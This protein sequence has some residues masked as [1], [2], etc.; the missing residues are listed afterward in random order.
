MPK[1]KK[2]D[3]EAL[4]MSIVYAL[5]SHGKLTFS[6][7]AKKL[8][9]SPSTVY[10]RVAKL[11][12]KGV[13]KGY[14]VVVDRSKSGRGTGAILLISIDNQASIEN[15]SR[16]VSEI[17]EVEAVY[18]IGGEADIVALLYAPS[19]EELR[20]L[21]N[22]KINSIPGVSNVTPLVIMKTYKENGS[23]F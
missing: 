19:I 5:K 13:I 18:E 6:E 22:D 9:V 1:L 12:R 3:S 15:V 11:E 23:L 8:H 2:K 17:L 14:T 20:K 10:N 16:S 21:V 7:L 4:D